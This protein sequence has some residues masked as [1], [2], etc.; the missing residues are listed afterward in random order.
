MYQKEIELNDDHEKDVNTVKKILILILSVILLVSSFSTAV[1]APIGQNQEYT[2][3][4]KISDTANAGTV[5]RTFGLTFYGTKGQVTHSNLFDKISGSNPFTKGKTRS[6]TFNHADLGII[7]AVEVTC[8]SD[9]VKLDYVRIESKYDG[10]ENMYNQIAVN[11]WIEKESEMFFANEGSIFKISILNGDGLFDGTSD[12]VSIRMT[13]PNGDTTRNIPVN[14][15]TRNGV[16]HRGQVDSFIVYSNE[17]LSSVNNVYVKRN[18]TLSENTDSW[19]PLAVSVQKF[20]GANSSASQIGFSSE[21]VFLCNDSVP[22]NTEIALTYRSEGN[23]NIASI[24]SEPDLW[25]IS[26]IVLLLLVLGIWFLIAKKKSRN[27]LKQEKQEKHEKQER[28]ET[29]KL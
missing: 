18:S 23:L 22:N 7:Y 12:I 4:L 3:T 26:G 15:Y 13:A 6:Y 1:A 24:F 2:V 9:A 14:V 19:Q 21:K 10:D 11:S 20:S 28:K 25:V 29:V 8:G 27:P 5:N 16:L 17:A